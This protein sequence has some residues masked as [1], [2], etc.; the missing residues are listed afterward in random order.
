MLCFP[1]LSV[2]LVSTSYDVLEGDSVDV[3]VEVSGL[4]EE[5][6][7]D[8]VTKELEGGRCG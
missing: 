4:T 3:C 8:V 2:V 1:D 7:V 6:V 5:I